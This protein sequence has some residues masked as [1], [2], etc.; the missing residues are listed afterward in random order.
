LDAAL[1]PPDCTNPL[2]RLVFEEALTVIRAAQRA[3]VALYFVDV[4]GY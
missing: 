4:R 1:D 3:K 2:V